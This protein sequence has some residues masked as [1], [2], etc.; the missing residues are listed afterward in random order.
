M[1]DLMLVGASLLGAIL[2]AVIALIPGLH[3]YTLASMLLVMAPMTA[4][5][6]S[7]EAMVLFLL[8]VVV[9]WTVL[10]MIPAIFLYAPDDAN[11]GAVLPA[12]K[13]LLQGRGAEATLL[14]GAGSL[15]AL[16]GLVLLAPLLDQ[17]FRPLHSILQP[18]TGW[19]LTAIIAF[20]LLGEWPRS[21]MLTTPLRR[22][23][24][25]WA[26]LGSGLLTFVLSGVL[27]FVLM[28]RNP[29]EITQANMALAPAFM[30]L[31]VLPGALQMLLFSHRPPTQ[32]PA[33]FDLP[34]TM[35]LR[36]TLTGLAGGLFAGFLPVVSGGIGGLLAGHATSRYD[37]R[38]F[39]VSQGASKVAYYVT[40]LMLFFVPGL[41][42]V[43]GGMAGML[44]T[45][46]VPYG[47]RMYALAVSSIALSGALSFILL[48]VFTR[49]AA[50]LANHLQPRWIALVTIGIALSITGMW[51]GWAGLG[52]AGVGMGI[53]L[54]PVLVGGRRMNC[55]GVLL[56]PITLNV[57][58]IGPDVARWL[59][60]L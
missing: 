1:S 24:S 6:S 41:N 18:H 19:M 59:G 45:T 36:A 3:A 8:G 46:Y 9:G 58:G 40:S 26:Y 4:A 49:A 35:L 37:N 11:I 16:L 15:A 48:L 27:G 31:F 56:L 29:L 28:Y 42:L 50:A 34:A 60:L 43:R 12:T 17:G 21:N 20:M 2:G 54:L 39:L 57:I 51:F 25:A 14:V 33:V 52:I 10:N 55:L 47:W 44:S 30:G 13:Y 5:A 23:L 32:Q 22:L 38:L 53:G 7:N